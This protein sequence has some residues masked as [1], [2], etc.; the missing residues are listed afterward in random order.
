[1]ERRNAW[2]NFFNHGVHVTGDSLNPRHGIE[3]NGGALTLYPLVPGSA[4]ADGDGVYDHDG[5]HVSRMID[6]SG[7]AYRL[8]TDGTYRPASNLS[9]AYHD[10]DDYMYDESRVISHGAA[11][12]TALFEEAL[13]RERLIA[14]SLLEAM[15]MAPARSGDAPAVAAPPAK[16]GRDA[17]AEGLGE[18]MEREIGLAEAEMRSLH[19]ALADALS[20]S[21]GPPAGRP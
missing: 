14:E 11:R 5:R 13:E 4:D 12:G 19:P 3:V 15:G 21:R 10:V 8:A 9:S 18:A 20:E 1:D 7:R 16:D 17:A 6:E 2:Q